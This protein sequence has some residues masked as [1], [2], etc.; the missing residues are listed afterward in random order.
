VRRKLVWR[1]LNSHHGLLSRRDRTF[2]RPPGQQAHRA[3]DVGHTRIFPPT[4]A[5]VQGGTR[6]CPGD[7]ESGG[8]KVRRAFSPWLSCVSGRNRRRSSPPTGTGTTI[9]LFSR[10]L[11]LIDLGNFCHHNV[12]DRSGDIADVSQDISDLP[13]ATFHDRP[14]QLQPLVLPHPSHT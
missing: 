7:I 3:C 14:H 8:Q 5:P 2:G 13:G 11:V 12:D 6:T 1:R 10:S 4:R 9:L